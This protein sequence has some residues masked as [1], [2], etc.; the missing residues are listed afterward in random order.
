MIKKIFLYL[1]F[2]LSITFVACKKKQVFRTTEDG[3]KYYFIEKNNN[4]KQPKLGGGAIIDVDV[5]W[6]DSLIFSSN[7]LQNDFIVVVK[8]TSAA[9]IDRAIMMMHQGDSAIFK[10]NA[11]KFLINKVNMTI[12]KGMTNKDEMIFYIRLR[13]VLS[14]QK[15]NQI[16]Q[17]YLDYRRQIEPQLIDDYIKRN[18]QYNFV[19][20]SNGL[21]VSKI[22]DGSGLKPVNG[23][24]VFVNYI[25]YFING[26]PFSS[27]LKKQ[28]IFKFK[29]GDQKVI[30]GLELAIRQ[31]REGEVMFVIIPSYLA[32]GEEGLL[33]LIPPYSPL[34]FQ[35]EL[36]KVKP[37][38][39]LLH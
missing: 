31:M 39:I 35:V 15:V 14:P 20:Q 7:D 6:K 3:I 25:A 16:R 19:L 26:E 17:K 33:D 4:A 22:K 5:Y 2:V 28:Q 24:S 1:F 36:K 32:Y 29:I 23:D 10:L 38:Q 34:V 18:S 21:F 37:A 27:T 8:D 11:V 12:P 13:K 30:P 9:S